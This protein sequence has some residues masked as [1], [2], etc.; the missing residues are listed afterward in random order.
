MDVEKDIEILKAAVERNMD[1]MVLN[2]VADFGKSYLIGVAFKDASKGQ[3]MDPYY[4]VE[5]KSFKLAGFSPM[6]DIEKFKT[7]IRKPLYLRNK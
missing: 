2:V 7:A 4:L 6:M 1:G 3:V 5:K